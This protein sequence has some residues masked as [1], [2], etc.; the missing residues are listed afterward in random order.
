M[1]AI[2]VSE[3]ATLDKD[4]RAFK[5]ALDSFSFDTGERYFE[6]RAGDKVAEYGLTGLIVGG[7]VAAAAKTGVLKIL[8]KFSLLILVGI[9]ALFAGVIRWIRSLS[10]RAA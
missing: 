1:N 9:G 5:T 6:Y 4:I 8:G 7:A 10:Q 2:L 3:P